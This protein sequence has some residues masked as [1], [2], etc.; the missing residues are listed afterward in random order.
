MACSDTSGHIALAWRANSALQSGAIRGVAALPVGEG[1]MMRP[2]SGEFSRCRPRVWT[3]IVLLVVAAPVVV[4]NLSRDEVPPQAPPAPNLS[5]GW[6]L[7]WYECEFT[8]ASTGAADPSR[9]DPDLVQWSRPRLA[10][11]VAMWCVMLAVEGV[12]VTA[13]ESRNRHRRRNRRLQRTSEVK[14]CVGPAKW[15]RP[16]GLS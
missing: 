13:I 15:S 11:N 5:F 6:P 3:L 16:M 12:A 14:D 1:T 10:G 7:I 9:M 2:K 4:A 8:R